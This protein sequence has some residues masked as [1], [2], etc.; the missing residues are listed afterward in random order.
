MKLEDLEIPLKEYKGIGPKTVLKLAKNKIKTIKD[1]LYF[2]PYKYQDLTQ[3]K[4]IKD[5]KVGETAVIVGKLTNLKLFP[6]PKRK[7]FILNAIISDETGSLKVIW[8]NQPFLTRT[9]KENTLVA[10]YGKLVRNSFGL[11]IQSPKF[12][13]LKAKEDF[14]KRII[15]VYLEIEG[16]RS[17]YLAKVIQ[18]VLEKY[19]IENLIDPLPQEI[20]KK[21]NYPSLGQ[22]IKTLHQPQD[23][24]SINLAKERLSFE[25][26]LYLEL[27]LFLE[28]K[29]LQK[30]KAPIIE[31]D[32]EL[33]NKFL[34]QFD[35]DLTQGQEKVLTEI[36]NDLKKG[37]PMNR[38]LQGETGAGKTLIAEIIALNVVKN[39][40]QVI[41]MAPTEILAQQHFQRFVKHFALFDYGLGL[42][43]SGQIFY[44]RKGFRASKIIQEI[45]RLLGLGEIKIL[46]GT[47]SLIE[48]PLNFQKIGL[49]II[50]EQQRF[51]V[52]QR[53][54]LLAQTKQEFLPHFL[55]MTATPIPRTLAL[56]FYGDLDF[57]YL[58]EKPF[59]QKEIKTYVISPKKEK[60]M[61]NFV[62]KEISEGHQVFVICPRV[63]EKEDEIASVKKEYERVKEIFSVRSVKIA[64]LHG[65]M[66]SEEKEKILKAMQK[67]E[68]QIL[69]SSSVVE[70]GIDLPLAT[71][72]II[73][74]PERFGLAQLYQLR[75]RVGRSVH[76]GYC[77]LVPQK[78]SLKS[79][80][81][82]K[83]FLQA[84]SALELSEYDLKL[85]GGGELLGERQAGIPDLAM[86]A[87][88]NLKLIEKARK[89]AEEILNQDP[90][91]E[92]YPNL[93]KEI[94]KR[95]GLILA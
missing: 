29:N 84:K 11:N 86:K 95:K 93:K 83:Y 50:D 74:S 43:T 1:L 40:L 32:Q 71:V 87:L 75:G 22:A 80:L 53:R 44:A 94:N 21:F 14:Q 48:N 61:W 7:M 15:P 45:N 51:G 66:K 52:E 58:E 49:V 77:F 65:K 35:F 5:I 69:V 31:K 63:E 24:A 30:N 85:R 59:G 88:S 19:E 13:V 89:I 91:I 56:A 38:L 76:Q 67:N 39:D 9:L 27:A 16:I 55:S 6:T 90:K 10:L 82:L 25:E 23:F 70:V 12:E 2:F 4:K 57:S 34:I 26:L 46:I 33:T 92:K 60:A 79:K 68:I 73:Q 36:F 62:K 47:H 37:M 78:L 72:I 28:R 81:R 41:F 18:T 64:M 3:I 42:L 54:K 8:Y 20:L 17:N